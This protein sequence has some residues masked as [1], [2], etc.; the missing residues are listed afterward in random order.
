MIVSWEPHVSSVMVKKEAAKEKDISDIW[1]I[2][3][4]RSAPKN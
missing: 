3:W 4:K 2:V 1:K